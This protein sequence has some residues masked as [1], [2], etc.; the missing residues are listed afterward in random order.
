MAEKIS[1]PWYSIVSGEQLRQG[2]ILEDYPIILPSSNLPIKLEEC[3]EYDKYVEFNWEHRDLIVMTQSCDLESRRTPEVLLCP[4]WK[5]SDYTEGPFVK[6]ENWENV[7]KG[8]FPA[9]HVL[10]RCSINGFERAHRLVDFR[11]A[12][13]L[14]A[15]FVR[16]KSA[17]SGPRIRLMPPYR[18]HL[19]QA[20]ARFFMR[21]GLPTDIPSFIK[22]K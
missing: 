5:R 14:P 22:K 13:T 2:D 17:V 15:E 4:V 3:D 7:R 18:E 16:Y 20:F 11:H 1:Y 10:H 12:Y 9:Y 6:V 19:A 21:V 8:R